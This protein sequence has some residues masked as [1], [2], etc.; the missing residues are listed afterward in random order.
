M[1]DAD[2]TGVD[3]MDRAMF[4]MCRSRGVCLFAGHIS[5]EERF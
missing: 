2:S 4:R 1:K 3:F 5:V